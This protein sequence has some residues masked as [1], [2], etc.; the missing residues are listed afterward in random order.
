MGSSVLEGDQCTIGRKFITEYFF[1]AS[2]RDYF[3]SIGLMQVTAKQ[4]SQKRR[5]HLSDT[6]DLLKATLNGRGP[7]SGKRLSDDAIISNAITSLI[8]GHETTSSMLGFLIVLLVQNPVA[9]E[10]AQKEVDTTV[11]AASDS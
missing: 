11:G 9:L 7:K 8:A 1:G 10:P 2:T 5:R 3:E 6:V 4:T